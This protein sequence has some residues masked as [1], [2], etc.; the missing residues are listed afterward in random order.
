MARRYDIRRV[1]I[2]QSYS[3]A[4]VAKLLRVH[5]RTVR[6]WIK[7]GLA[8]VD[9]SRPCLIHGSDL[10]A[11]LKALHPAKKP[12]RP[13]EFF[14][15]PCRTP[16]LP[17]GGF[18]EYR[19]SGP[20]RGALAGLCPTCGRVINRRVS[21]AEIDR[22]AGNLEVLFPAPSLRI[23]DSPNLPSNHHFKQD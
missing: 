17:D 14:C 20:T 3:V 4:E 22:A 13:G 12:L 1:K 8:L 11:F 18:A 15:L 9:K 7:S 16:T 10:L 6:S 21:F 2:H 19:P 23:G 5:P